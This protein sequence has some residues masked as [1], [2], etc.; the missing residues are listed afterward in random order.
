[1]LKPGKLKILSAAA[2]VVASVFFAS[3]TEAVKFILGP[4]EDIE[5]FQEDTLGARTGTGVNANTD[6]IVNSLN[7][8]TSSTLGVDTVIR[9]TSAS[10][11]LIEDAAGQNIFNVDT[12]N[13][14]TTFWSKDGA[15]QAA[16][17]YS[18]DAADPNKDNDLIIEN[19]TGRDIHLIGSS[20]ENQVF[21]QDRIVRE[22]DNNTYIEFGS[23]SYQ[24][25]AG[26]N[27][28]VRFEEVGGQD[29]AEFNWND[30]DID[31]LMHSDNGSDILFLEA[32]GNSSRG[33]LHRLSLDAGIHDGLVIIENVTTTLDTVST[34]LITLAIE[35][36][37]VYHIRAIANAIA[38][39]ENDYASYEFRATVYR[40][41]GNAILVNDLNTKVHA[42]ETVGAIGWDAVVDVEGTDAVFKVTGVNSSTWA[43]FFEYSNV[44]N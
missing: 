10:A 38:G 36:K 29:V 24:F 23:D 18:Q 35:D 1:M 15:N 25:I 37:N 2:M 30:E 13:A 4:D 14:S 43:G 28:F 20:G 44:S 21:I 5:I 26:G 34:T 7:V 42:E 6:L 27:N 39:T 11:F 17:Y 32:G 9:G 31:Y 22:G 19:L 16:I 8:T 40:D 33:A 3:K 12:L 41:G